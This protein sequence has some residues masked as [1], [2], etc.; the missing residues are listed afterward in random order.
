VQKPPA[1]L[2]VI[3][4]V[5]VQLLGALPGPSPWSLYWLDAVD[6]LLEDL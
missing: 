1:A 3:A 2:V 5:G 6:Q 4:F